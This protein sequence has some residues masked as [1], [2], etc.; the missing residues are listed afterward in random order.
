V[1]A[2]LF[3]G[4]DAIEV[5]W[6]RTY[7]ET[8][9]LIHEHLLAN[10][11]R[12]NYGAKTFARLSSDTGVSARTLHECVQFHRCYPIVRLVAQFGWNRC[13]LLCQVED[14]TERAALVLQLKRERLEA[15]DL[16]ERVRTLNAARTSAHGADESPRPAAKV[17]LLTPKRGTIGVHRLVAGDEE[18]L[19][20]DLGCTSFFDLGPEQ[21][22]GLKPGDLV[23]LDAR[24][25]ATKAGDAKKSDLYTYA[26]RIL[27]VVDGDTLW[28][29]FRLGPRHWLKEK[30]RT[31]P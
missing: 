10:Q 15:V 13:R 31:G 27:R 26:A 6:V 28:L 2:V 25:R 12:A 30:V 5:A 17:N 23:Q 1:A 3:A 11:S 4:R 18:A 9:R 14:E 22:E 8:G 20:V 16:K 7:H 29:S 19:A 21:A 24:G